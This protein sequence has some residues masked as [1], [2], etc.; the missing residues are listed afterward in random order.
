MALSEHKVLSLSIVIPTYRREQV[1]LNTIDDLLPLMGKAGFDSELILVDQTLR[2]DGNTGRK[3]RQFHRA[4][5]IRW[6]RPDVPHITRS[7]NLGVC[8]AKG[9]IVLFLDDDIV[10]SRGLLTGHVDAYRKQPAAWA[11]AGQVLQPWDEPERV[12][13]AA[14]GG[15]IHRYLDFPFYSVEGAFVENAM[16]GN[17]SVRK[18]RFIQLGGFDENFTPPVASRFE[19]E[20]AKRLVRQ[21]GR[22]WFEPAASIRHLRVSTGGTRTGGNHLTSIS[23]VHGAGDY[24]YACRCAKGGERLNYILKRPFREIRTKFHLK[25]PWYIPLK[26]VGEVRAL[27]DT[28]FKGPKQP[29]YMDA[30][31]I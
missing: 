22:I 18:Q 8:Q 1:L 9:S 23:P 2:H 26:L 13:Y 27:W 6:V 5:K 30:K 16:A 29:K 17:L 31:Q 10:P 21:G 20:F 15:P 28:I 4:G 12:S 11:V 25:H 7:M 3:L 19:S 24:Y 14:R